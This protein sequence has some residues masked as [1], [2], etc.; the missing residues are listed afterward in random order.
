MPAIRNI[1]F[2]GQYI[3]ACPTAVLQN[4]HN[5][6]SGNKNQVLGWIFDNP[7]RKA[8]TPRGHVTPVTGKNPT[9]SLINLTD[10]PS[11]VQPST[12]H[13]HDVTSQKSFAHSQHSAFKPIKKPTPESKA[14]LSNP[15][16]KDVTVKRGKTAD[17]NQLKAHQNNGSGQQSPP[18]SSGQNIYMQKKDISNPNSDVSSGKKQ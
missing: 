5:Q 17:E 8:E 1:S 18:M 16:N 6:L 7:N 12:N 3:N 11:D 9:I 13:D 15:E 2:D 10:K 4:P 14:S